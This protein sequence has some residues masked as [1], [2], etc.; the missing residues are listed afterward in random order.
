MDYIHTQQ[1]LQDIIDLV[2][3]RVQKKEKIAEKWTN[4]L[5]CGD[6]QGL[7]QEIYRL[8]T[9]RK[10]QQALKKW[11]DYFERNEKRMQYHAFKAAYIPCG[12]GCVES[13]IRRIINLRLK[14]AVRFGN[15]TWPSISCF[16]VLNYFQ[17]DGSSF[18]KM[19]PDRW[20]LPCYFLM[21]AKMTNC[22]NQPFHMLDAN[23]FALMSYFANAPLRRRCL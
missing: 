6:I 3:K 1:N 17:G 22:F 5:W 15:E 20:R 13:A 21:I 10:Q 16:C 23:L 11:H 2:A 7:Q 9:G 18:G 8:L 12:S 19:S 14:S 4:L